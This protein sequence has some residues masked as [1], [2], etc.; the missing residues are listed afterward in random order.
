MKNYFEQLRTLLAEN[1]PDFGDSDAVLAFLYE[2][3][4]ETHNMDDAQTKADFRALYQVMSGMT[5]PAMDTILDPL[6]AL[7]RDH[8]RSG[9]I[10]G[11]RIGVRL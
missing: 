10:E 11:V 3:Y 8:Q 6:C 9:F 2:A 4:N 5:L 1:P 7:C